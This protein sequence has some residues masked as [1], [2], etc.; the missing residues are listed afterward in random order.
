[1]KLADDNRMICKYEYCVYN[2]KFRCAREMMGERLSINMYGMCMGLSHV[3]I[4]Q[5]Y[6]DKEKKR[7]L[8]ESLKRDY[9]YR[10]KNNL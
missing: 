8:R 2:S 1:M 4:P 9:E 3:S 7:Q 6:L 5:A 10:T